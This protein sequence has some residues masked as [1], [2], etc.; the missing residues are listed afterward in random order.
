MGAQAAR[1]NLRM[2]KE[3]KLLLTDPPPSASFPLLSHHSSDSLS[4]ILAHI[5][6]PEDTVYTNGVFKINI[7]IPERYPFQPPIVTFATPIY[8]PNIDTGGRICLDILNLPPKGAWQP[9]LNISTVLTSILLLLTEPNPDDG[10][11]CEASK[12]YKY[13]RQAFDQKA[14]SMTEKYARDESIENGSCSQNTESHLNPTLMDIEGE[15]FTFEVDKSSGKHKNLSPIE[16]KYSLESTSS[17]QRRVNDIILKEA[18]NDDLV[19]NQIEGKS[20]NLQRAEKYNKFQDIGK[21]HSTSRKLSLESSSRKQKIS[22]QCKENVLSYQCPPVVEPREAAMGS[23]E[24]VL[25]E[26]DV[27]QYEQ[28]SH[29][30]HTSGDGNLAS[31]PN[32]GSE[33]ICMGQSRVS[34]GDNTLPQPLSVNPPSKRL[35][36][37]LRMPLNTTHYDKQPQKDSV[38]KTGSGFSGI[39]HKR[40][41]LAGRK[42]SLGLATSLQSQERDNKENMISVSGA[43]LSNT[44]GGESVHKKVFNSNSN[45]YP[46]KQLGIRRKLPLEPLDKSN[47]SN[48][49]NIQLNS[50]D[51]YHNGY[52]SKLLRATEES[53]HNHIQKP[54]QENDANFSGQVKHHSEDLPIPDSAIVL[55]SEDSDDDKKV[56]ARPKLSLTRKRLGRKLNARA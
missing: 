13:N 30:V 19:V 17:N 1:L 3:L 34:I 12:E 6:G 18:I 32:K 55:D 42:Q 48:D 21:L 46:K 44:E 11:M 22:F 47:W 2:Q 8:H 9:S 52:P 5:K 43:L 37:P 38:D 51:D 54:M 33:N 7:Q 25:V 10:L 49:G 29:Q 35:L 41:G 31:P 45:V 36:S 20:P 28:Q 39:K 24:P 16:N 26:K 4:S 14:R 27:N 15:L 56:T 50:C 40:L 23:T 53:R